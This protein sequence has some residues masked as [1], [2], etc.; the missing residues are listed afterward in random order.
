[1]DEAGSVDEAGSGAKPSSSDPNPKQVS[2]TE[3]AGRGGAGLSECCDLKCLS[4]LP[5]PGS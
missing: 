1:M 2:W 4:F 3:A 5:L